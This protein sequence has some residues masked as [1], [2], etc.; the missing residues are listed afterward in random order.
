[1]NVIYSIKLNVSEKNV[2]K[3]LILKQKDSNSRFIDCAFMH[4]RFMLLIRTGM[5]VL[6]VTRAD[7]QHKSFAGTINDN[8]TVRIPVTNWM[9][10]NAGMIECD[11]SVFDDDEKLTSALFSAEVQAS[12]NPDGSVSPDD[13]N[14]DIA[15]QIVS[16]AQEA[17]KSAASS[18]REAAAS[19]ELATITNE[20][21]LGSEVYQI[22]RQGHIVLKSAGNTQGTTP[23]VS[24]TYSNIVLPVKKGDSVTLYLVPDTSAQSYK[25][26]VFTDSNYVSVERIAVG[27]ALSGTELIAPENGYFIANAT[28]ESKSF[29]IK[30]GVSAMQTIGALSASIEDIYSKYGTGET[31]TATTE[32]DKVYRADYPEGQTTNNY[33][34][35]SYS[36]TGGNVL[37]ISVAPL[38]SS[39]AYKL[40]MWYDARGNYIGCADRVGSSQYQYNVPVIVPSRATTL[41]ISTGTAAEVTVKKMV[42]PEQSAQAQKSVSM[43]GNVITIVNDKY[44]YVMSKH[45]NNNLIDLYQVIAKDGTVLQT[46]GTDCQGPYQVAAINNAD[47]DAI[48]QGTTYTGGN[49]AYA[50]DGTSG[51]PTARTSSFKVYADGVELADGQTLSWNDCVSVE[52]TNYVQGWNTKKADGTGR[53]ILMESPTWRFLPSDR[54]ET[55]NRIEALEDIRISLYYGLQM[56]AAWLGGVLLPSARRSVIAMSEFKSEAQGGIGTRFAGY[57]VTALGNGISIKMGYDPF[58]DLG[59]GNAITS[60]EIKLTRIHTSTSKLYVYMVYNYNFDED[61][62]MRYAGYYQFQ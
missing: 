1:M 17:A 27:D 6:N 52:W 7:G 60:D 24:E 8:G 11:V 33:V 38:P 57:N 61:E 20:N 41:R 40:A 53:E 22:D 14:V 49:H 55:E 32:S 2:L 15:L 5:V 13:P 26:Y 48:A 23:T 25:G 46:F 54:I 43:F 37:S 31:L 39:V 10:E 62:I 42:I 4:G 35:R 47:G 18:A 50:F 28:S 56:A 16:A 19:A 51:T 9:V 12:A 59:D 45:G 58:T 3:P 30:N 34:A 36:V 29:V 21:V 44:A